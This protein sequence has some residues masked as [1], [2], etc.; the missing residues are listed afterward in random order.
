[1]DETAPAEGIPPAAGLTRVCPCAAAMSIHFAPVLTPACSRVSL[2]SSTFPAWI[3]FCDW[4][5][6]PVCCSICSIAFKIVKAGSI[7]SCS[8]ALPCLTDTEIRVMLAGTESPRNR[9]GNS[10]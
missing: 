6:T 4:T 1:M 8:T 9:E 2:G 5:D 7:S 10:G 3:S